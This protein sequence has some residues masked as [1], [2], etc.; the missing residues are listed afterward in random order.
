MVKKKLRI[1]SWNKMMSANVPT[2]TSLSR[3][4]P[5]SF[6]SKI[7]DT[8]SQNTMKISTPKNTFSERDSF[9][10]L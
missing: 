1:S 8:K 6:I 10:T 4:E 3:I 7:C 2:L 9:I 5:S